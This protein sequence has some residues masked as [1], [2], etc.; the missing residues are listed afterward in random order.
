MFWSVL[1]AS[2]FSTDQAVPGAWPVL[3]GGSSP[4][5]MPIFLVVYGFFTR[6][7][8]SH[9]RK[10]LAKTLLSIMANRTKRYRNVVA[11]AKIGLRVGFTNQ[12]RRTCPCILKQGSTFFFWTNETRKYYSTI[13]SSKTIVVARTVQSGVHRSDTLLLKIYWACMSSPYLR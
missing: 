5:L 9:S 12:I 2:A 8:S 1:N 10:K 3:T 4:V 11:T 7:S 6:L 13:Q